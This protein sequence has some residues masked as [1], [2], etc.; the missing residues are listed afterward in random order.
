MRRILIGVLLVVS[1]CGVRGELPAG[2]TCSRWAEASGD[3]ALTQALAAATSGTCVVAQAGTYRQALSVPAGVALVGEAGAR[4]EFSGGTDATAVVTLAP[5]ATLAGVSVTATAAGYGV[6][7]AGKGQ[8][9]SSVQVTGG[10][11]GGV[12]FWCE[13]DCRTDEFSELSNV[14][15]TGAAVGLMT[16][17]VRVRVKNG[18]VSKSAGGGLASGY[19]VVASA[20][21]V[22]EG[23]NLSVEENEALGVLIDGAGATEASLTN[24]TVKDNKGRGLWVQGLSGTMAAPR[25]KLVNATVERNVLVGLGAR[26]STGISLTGGRIAGTVT[27]AT[28]GEQPGQVVMVGDGVGL[29]SGTGEVRFEGASLQANQRAQA[30]VDAAGTGVVFAPTVSV[31]AG[32]AQGLVVQRTTSMVDAMNVTRPAAGQE[33]AV[34]APTLGVPAR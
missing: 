33:L 2:V 10:K 3:S 11:K 18:V 16:R 15:I 12:I 7:G 17:G 25:L 23:E 32:S 22:L 6:S 8:R 29:F 27:G 31:T 1:G 14:I 5:N 19:G 9:L 20:G 21:A 4:V 34:S 24:V 30:L 28:A 26:S 13:E